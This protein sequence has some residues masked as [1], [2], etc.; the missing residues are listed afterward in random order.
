MWLVLA[1][2]SAALGAAPTG[3]WHPDDL[4]PRSTLFVSASERLQASYGE[5]ERAISTLSAALR[6]YRTAL[7]LL[8]AAAPAAE[9]DRLER[10]EHDYQRQYAVVQAFADDLVTAFDG[11]FQVSVDRAVAA[12]GG[13]VECE[14][15]ISSGPNIPGIPSRRSANPACHGEDLNAALAA[16][17]D[18]DPALKS[19][20][21]ELLARPWPEVALAPEPQAPIVAAGAPAPAARWLSVHDLMT[22]GARDAL[23]GI[24]LR[25]DE[26]RDAIHAR[27]EEGAS[28]AELKA[29]EPE[30]E[31]IEAATAAVRAELAAPVLAASNAA[32]AKWKG[33]PATGWCANP[34]ALGGCT[35]EDASRDLVGRLIDDKKV[36][37]TWP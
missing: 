24:D 11:A 14:A 26:A 12:A 5:R 25:D 15:T 20:I 13:A 16:A 1:Q 17:V 30:A 22:A 31:R 34:T 27:L 3:Y 18:A 7:D 36:A 19:A 29:L 8:G 23:Q 9:R 37:K 33:D 2:I 6:N 10:L 21:D 28:T 35:G 32:M 4:A